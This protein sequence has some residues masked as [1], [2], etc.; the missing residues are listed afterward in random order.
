MAVIA[1]TGIT[2]CLLVLNLKGPLSPMDSFDIVA[3]SEEIGWQRHFRV[4]M[5]DCNTESAEDTHFTEVVA[6][7][8]AFPVRVF[9]NEEDALAWLRQ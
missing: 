3:T 8:R 9:D 5:V 1:K 7:N 6:S 4:A 2:D